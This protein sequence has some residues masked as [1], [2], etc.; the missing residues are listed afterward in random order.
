MTNCKDC[1]C[2]TVPGV[3]SARCKECWDSRLGVKKMKECV[4]LV[5]P[6]GVGKTTHASREYPNHYR[7]SQDEMGKEGAEANFKAAL[8]RGDNIVID[9]MNFNKEQRSRFLI[10]AKAAG[11]DTVIEEIKI[12]SYGGLLYRVVNREGHPTIAQNDTITAKKVIDMYYKDYQIPTK[13]EADYVVVSSKNPK[14]LD[15][16]IDFYAG[17]RFIVIGDV[18]GCT[19]EVWDLLDNVNYNENKDI[20]IFCGDL[21]DRG[22]GIGN[23]LQ[24]YIDNDNWYSVRGN[25][26]DKFIRYLKGNKVNKVSIEKTIEQT[27]D[28]N[29]NVLYYNLMDMPY[30]IRFG[31]N[32]VVHAGFNPKLKNPVYTSKEFCLYAR[33]YDETLGTFTNDESAPYWYQLMD[34]STNCNYFFGHEIHEKQAHVNRGVFAMDAGCVFGN[35]LRGAVVTL[36]ATEIVEVPSR[37]PKAKVEKSWDHINKLEPYDKLVEQG[38]L[39]KQESGDL[40]LYNYTDKCTYDKHWNKYTLESRGLIINKVTGETVARPFPKFFNLGENETCTLDKMPSGDYEVSEKLDGSL[41]ILY[42]DPVADLYKIATRG[43]FTSPQSQKATLMFHDSG[44]A[45]KLEELNKISDYSDYTL[46]FEIIYPENRVNP[47]ARLVVD[48]GSQETLVLLGGIHKFQYGKELSRYELWYISDYI[49]LPIAKKYDYTIEQMIELQ[50]TLPKTEE[51]FVVK[52]SNNYRV[53]IKGDEYCKFQRIL[54]SITPLFMWELMKENLEAGGLFELKKEY[55]ATIPEEILPEAEEIES[56]LKV[57]Y[58][59]V[60]SDMTMEYMHII[61][62]VGGEARDLGKHIQNPENNVK[63]V[64]SIFPIHTGNYKAMDKYILKTIRPTGNML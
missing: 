43:S 44:A 48:Y 40:V 41:G 21:V 57:A 32:Y 62:K 31:H 30:V 53:K 64:A 7:I 27:K 6:C 18:H 45:S 15:L 2:E 60:L 14:F 35:K 54:N 39:N 56:K 25:H 47:G 17:K 12:S 20:V 8:E 16:S 4:V 9:R 55:K 59:R 5:G 26:D 38:Y 22:P 10:P 42:K 46:L 3:G 19:K 51:G 24:D 63:H 13:N 50:K 33:K 34:N 36:N 58:N 23:I 61:A 37:Q 1:G 29:Q 11:Y 49:G 28:M 52:Y